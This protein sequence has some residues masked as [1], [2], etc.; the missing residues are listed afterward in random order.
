LDSV[1]L[2]LQANSESAEEPQVA[3]DGRNFLVVRSDYN[4]VRGAR[5]NS[6]GQL[7]DTAD[8]D[9]CRS[10]QPAG[11]AY[12][13]GVYLVN[14]NEHYDA[15]RVTPEGT[16]LDSTRHWCS[17]RS[18]VGFDG[19]DFLVLCERRDY[20]GVGAMRIDPDGRLL[21]STQFLLIGANTGGHCVT[22]AAMAANSSGGVGVVFPSYE[23]T[24]WLATRIRVATFPAVLSVSS[25][26]EPVH[27][28]ALRVR[29]NPASGTTSLSFA[30][31]EEGPVQV[32]AFDAAGRRCASLFSGRM[33]AGRQSIPL[34]TRRLANGV[35]FLRL[36]AEAATHS[37]RLVISH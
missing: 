14:D 30:L 3:F 17:N 24:P 33:N 28:V 1:P 37:T 36:A 20:T 31:G 15:W 32:T 35:Y 27:L 19:T 10:N 12:G 9:I 18:R 23:H 6:A 4:D 34:D 25:Q 22:D 26:P 5:V 11:L 21:D 7:L 8:I 2:L 13:D 29:P 16:V